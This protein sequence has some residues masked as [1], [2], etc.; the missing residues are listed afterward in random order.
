MSKVKG[1]AQNVF[2]LR[3][4]KAINKRDVTD[5]DSFQTSVKDSQKLGESSSI[6]KTILSEQNAYQK[7]GM[8]YHVKRPIYARENDSMSD[9][10]I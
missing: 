9:D 2:S 1:M 6:D 10:S 3:K 4:Q 5:N 7:R 8:S